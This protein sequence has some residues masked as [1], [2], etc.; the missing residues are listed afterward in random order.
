MILNRLFFLFAVFTLFNSCSGDEPT[1]KEEV[2]ADKP[3]QGDLLLDSQGDVDLFV[4]KN[5]TRVN[6]TI[7]I[8][9]EGVS[10][11]Q[12]LTTLTQINGNIQLL[13]TSLKDL[14]GLSNCNLKDGVNIDIIN[15]PLLENIDGLQNMTASLHRLEIRDVSNLQSIIGL[16]NIEDVTFSLVISNTEKLTDINALSNL[17]SSLQRISIRDNALLEDVSGIAGIPAVNDF[18]FTQNH[19]VSS[20]VSSNGTMNVMNILN[21]SN[22]TTLKDFCGISFNSE[23]GMNFYIQNNYY[24]PSE[25]D[26]SSGNC[27]AE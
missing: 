4:S 22:N 6:G 24:N 23:S 13:G 1:T 27:S 14:D 15:N 25:T 11:I 21:I 12:G 20:L 3:Y 16:S 7:Q 9:G 19:K 18:T 2:V 26:L 17:S 5:Y 8:S 10:D